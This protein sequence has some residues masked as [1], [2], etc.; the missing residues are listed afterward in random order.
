[1][2]IGG[3]RNDIFVL[4]LVIGFFKEKVYFCTMGGFFRILKKS[5]SELISHDCKSHTK[6]RIENKKQNADLAGFVPAM[7]NSEC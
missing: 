5:L 7:W 3:A 4:F 2:R 1:M 6:T